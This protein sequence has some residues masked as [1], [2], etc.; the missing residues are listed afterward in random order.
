MKIS[1]FDRTGLYL[2]EEAVYIVFV[3]FVGQTVH[4]DR[5]ARLVRIVV[6][7]PKAK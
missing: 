3:G 7:T 6:A 1:Q 4:L 5:V 2:A